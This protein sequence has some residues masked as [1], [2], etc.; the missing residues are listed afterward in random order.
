MSAA[1]RLAAR[2]VESPLT[3]DLIAA[4]T[5]ALFAIAWFVLPLLLGRE[6]RKARHQPG[7]G[8]CG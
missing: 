1:V 5:A 6:S 7:R 8:R 3:A 2:W 4:G